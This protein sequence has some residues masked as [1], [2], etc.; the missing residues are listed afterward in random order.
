MRSLLAR[1][2][3]VAAAVFLP[4]A[5]PVRAD[6]KKSE[7]PSVLIRLQSVNDLL[8]SV[9]FFTKLVPE[10][11]AEPVKQGLGL[12]KS[13]IDEKKGIEGIDVN[14]PIGIYAT[15]TPEVTS[16]PVVALIPIADEA[17]ILAALKDRAMVEVKKGKDGVYETTPPNS[18]MT[19]YFRFANKYAYVT[20]NDPENISLKGLPKPADVLGGKASDLLSATIRIDRL[21]DQM[22][23]LAIGAIETQLAAGKDQPIPNETPAMK[24]FKEKMIDEMTTTMKSV[25]TDGEQVSLRL[26][27]DQQSGETGI[28]FEIGGVKG[29]KLAKDFASIKENKS[30]AGGALQSSD[31]CMTMN[32]SL[33]LAAN[34]KKLLP[35][36]IDDLLN[37]AKKQ[38]PGEVQEKLKPLVD[39]L[40][41]TLKAGELDAG[42][43]MVGPNKDGKLTALVAAKIVDGKKIEAAVKAVAKDI[44]PDF[45]NLLA[46][47][48]EDLPGGYKLH[49]IKVGDFVPED[50]QKAFGKS[51]VHLTFRDDLA[52]IAF[53]PDAKE[54]LKKALASKPADVGVFKM[55]MALAKLV[56][57]LAESAKEA[58]EA[59]KAAKRIFGDSTKSDT[60]KITVDGGE[61]MKIKIAIQGKALQFLGAV[62]EMNKNKDN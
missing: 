29:S 56:P 18:P 28:E 19:I 6:D 44:P 38:A 16:S 8:K 32:L 34:L 35:A 61:T 17:A 36:T 53:G 47:D 12:I 15:L 42:M 33:A 39:A 62:G 48:A 57:V 5:S 37:E 40:L 46:L 27:V 23:K 10:E 41:P 1:C 45:A 51:D 21:P 13:L 9:E 58:A 22:K 26:N 7:G 4:F 24:A 30:V 25:L 20:A 31:T 43:A 50:A 2:M 49:T 14:L 55:E 59:K 52:L 11:D 3:I 60:F 54:V